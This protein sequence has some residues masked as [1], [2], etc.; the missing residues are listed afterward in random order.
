MNHV[1]FSILSLLFV[2]LLLPRAGAATEEC[3]A[4]PTS[5]SNFLP[6]RSIPCVT[7]HNGVQLPTLSLGM[8]HPDFG[9]PHKESN[10]TFMGF[11]PERA[12]RQ[13]E[14]A[15]QHGIRSFDTALMYGTQPHLGQVLGQWW[16]SGQLHSREDV[17][18]TTKFFHI[19]S[20][21]FGL[22]VNHQVDL[23]TMKPEDVTVQTRKHVEQC[24][25]E[26]GV[27]Y[28]D[29]MLLH[30]PSVAGQSKEISRQRRLA[31]WNVL[32]SILPERMATSHWCLQL[33]RTSSATT[34]GRWRNHT[35]N[36][37]SD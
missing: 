13:V 33:F 27:G 32:G 23:E 22:A 1:N 3:V 24:L 19:P 18:I 28:I 10:A 31:A 25:K 36:G 20:P 14:L 4:I 11:Y 7:L 12:Y 29:L 5:D 8:A 30:W 17:F 26:L 16:T 35:T 21:D 6:P 37:E 15:L 9:S 34:H 2:C